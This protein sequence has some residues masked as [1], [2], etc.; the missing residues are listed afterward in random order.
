MALVLAEH[1]G[2]TASSLRWGG[3]HAA[4]GQAHRACASASFPGK[5]PTPTEAWK[6]EVALFVGPSPCGSGET[7]YYFVSFEGGFKSLVVKQV[8]WLIY[9]SAAGTASW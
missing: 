4:R 3:L 1:V 9:F 6:P 5:C 8:I 2:E 7:F